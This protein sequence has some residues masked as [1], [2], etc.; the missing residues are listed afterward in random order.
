MACIRG[1]SVRAARKM[2]P[3]TGIVLRSAVPAMSE[4][5]I[6]SQHISQIIGVIDAIPFR[7][8]LLAL[9]AGLDAA[10]AGEG[11]CGFAVAA[12]KSASLRNVQPAQPRNSQPHRPI[13]LPPRRAFNAEP[14]L[15]RNYQTLNPA[16]DFLGTGRRRR[17][18]CSRNRVSCHRR[19]SWRPKRP[20][21]TF[22]WI[23]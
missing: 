13:I 11:D 22:S 21:T 4:I 9:N 7:T 3:K 1:A 2:L 23:P 17:A 20:S 5:E 6:S 18:F 14:L 15:I 10:Q 12:Q 16:S 19:T 8:S